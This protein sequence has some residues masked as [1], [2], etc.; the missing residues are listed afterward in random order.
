MVFDLGEITS[1][2]LNILGIQAESV[3]LL[4]ATGIVFG[5]GV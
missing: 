4:S 1:T 2:D 5:A 3:P